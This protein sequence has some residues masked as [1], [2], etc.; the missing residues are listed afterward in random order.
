MAQSVTID[1]TSRADGAKYRI[2]F[3]H[4]GADKGSIKLEPKNG[5][6]STSFDLYDIRAAADN[7]AIRCS[8]DVPGPFDPTVTCSAMQSG[9]THLVRVQVSTFLGSINNDY[10]ISKED[11]D[12]LTGFIARAG[13]PH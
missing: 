8:A 3:A 7:S 6:N 1:A 11:H 9:Q 10:E 13:F 4:T 5:G 2:T 12:S